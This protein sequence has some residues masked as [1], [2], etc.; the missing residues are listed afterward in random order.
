MCE[1]GKLCRGR[2][3]R[4]DVK[5]V[6]AMGVAL[7]SQVMCAVG[8]LA[9]KRSESG[10]YIYLRLGFTGIARSHQIKKFSQISV[11]V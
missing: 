3:I 4:R 10:V 8:L 1:K 2:E 7:R 11:I 5:R 6:L 9:R